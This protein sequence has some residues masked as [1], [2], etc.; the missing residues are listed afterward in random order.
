MVFSGFYMFIALMSGL[1]AG[2]ALYPVLL[3]LVAK[4]APQLRPPDT[5]E[6]AALLKDG[7]VYD[8]SPPLADAITPADGDAMA[9]PDLHK[10]LS[11]RFPALPETYA[12]A[13]DMADHVCDA[14]DTDDP[15]RLELFKRGNRLRLSLIQPPDPA[16]LLR[17]HLLLQQNSALSAQAASFAQSPMIVWTLDEDGREV[18]HNAAYKT[19]R[20]DVL[21]ISGS[22]PGNILFE[23]DE[24]RLSED[25][26][27]RISVRDNSEFGEAWYEIHMRRSGRYRS[28]FAVDITP[29]VSAERAQRGYVQTL[30]KTFAQLGTGLAIFNRD[31]QLILFNP[32]LI[33]LT[34]M[35]AEFLSSRPSLTAFFDWLRDAR[36]MPEPRDINEWRDKLTA[37]TQEATDGT[38]SELWGLP[39]GLSYRVFGRPQADGAISF[40]F[41]DV[42]AEL[43]LTRNFVKEL[44]INHSLLNTLDQA[45][46]VFTHDGDL[47]FVNDA[48]RTMWQVDYDDNISPTSVRK[49]V[50]AWSA[51]C[52]PS[53]GWATIRAVLDDPQ[54]PQARHGTIRRKSGE[55]LT[56]TTGRLSKGAG[57]VGFTAV[58]AA[59]A[60]QENP[61][62]VAET[63]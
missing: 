25:V 40:L 29:V 37:L 58:A 39:N 31:R 46:A 61:Q 7:A 60:G 21:G 27:K 24:D 42:T 33:D 51:Q 10:L 6:V 12:A 36:F 13:L 5:G 23:V 62:P 59:A 26:P 47:L 45:L 11:A 17:H 1:G 3:R 15:A 52:M 28:F 49:A 56:F 35:S 30:T 22:E 2:L 48:F 50:S 9:W 53:D 8:I 4:P 16:H 63:L 55:V 34:R 32:A 14:A 19:F 41:E 18:W 38:F 54:Y 57:F 43:S 20:A 44:E